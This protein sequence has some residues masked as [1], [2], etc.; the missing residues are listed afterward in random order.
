MSRSMNAKRAQEVGRFMGVGAVSTAVDY[1]LLNLLAV[2][3]G[4]PVLVANSLS[5]PISSFVSYKLNKQVVFHDRMHGRRKTLILYAA[6]LGTGILIIQNSLIHVFAGPFS[7]TVAR[8]VE[9]A[10]ELVGLGHLSE[11]T[12]SIN[13]AK[14]FASLFSA[15]WNYV[16]LRRFVFVT[17]EEVEN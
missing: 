10:F 14:V 4:L 16:M 7:D 15:A 3:L 9:P 1:T 17:H 2:L 6:I 8:T 13:A 11:R 12:L 5:A